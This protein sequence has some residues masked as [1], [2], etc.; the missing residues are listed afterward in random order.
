[1]AP[2]EDELTEQMFAAFHARRRPA[3]FTRRNHCEECASTDDYLQKL[4]P[5]LL[6]ATDLATSKFLDAW[7]SSNDAGFAFLLPG[8]IA[9]ALQGGNDGLWGTIDIVLTKKRAGTL[10]PDEKGASRR[11]IENVFHTRKPETATGRKCL[12][13][14][15]EVLR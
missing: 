6:D 8:V 10:T 7:A 15:M 9:C 12:T 5:D 3:Q 11:C 4:E 2:N 13:Q 14:I 1:M